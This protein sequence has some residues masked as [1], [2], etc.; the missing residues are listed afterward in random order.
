MNQ[1]PRHE[2][3]NPALRNRGRPRASI[4]P[5]AVQVL[6]RSGLIVVKT[7][8]K[9]EALDL[10]DPDHFLVPALTAEM[11]GSSYSAGW[12]VV[13]GASPQPHRGTGA[14]GGGSAPGLELAR[15]IREPH[16]R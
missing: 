9:P 6:M 16:S 14:S 4:N 12:S 15:P 5:S 1:L 10:R 13:G 8:V 7:V 2:S 11:A 3:N